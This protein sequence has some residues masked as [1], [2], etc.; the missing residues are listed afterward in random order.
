MTTNNGDAPAPPVARAQIQMVIVVD[1]PCYQRAGR[2]MDD[3]AKALDPVLREHH[4]MFDFTGFNTQ[5]CKAAVM[6]DAYYGES[7]PA[8]EQGRPYYIDHS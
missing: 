3:V 1:V 7:A 8:T 6:N 5:P 2:M 4:A